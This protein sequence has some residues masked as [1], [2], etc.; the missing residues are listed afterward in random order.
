MV[1]E[2]EDGPDPNDLRRHAKGMYSERGYRQRYRRLDFYRP[3]RKQLEFH[4]L[5]APE[6]MLRSGNQEGK[7]HC[8]GAEIAVHATQ[9]YPA[10][11][12]GKRF[13]QRPPIERPFDFLG[14]A[15]ST[16]SIATRDGV[17]MKLQ[18]TFARM[19]DLGRD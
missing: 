17:Q 5:I 11:W 10:W 8:A 2:L 16:T 19:A 3:N 13:L 15:G 6:R 14:W 1:D 9:L 7:T 18:V 4:N 12:R